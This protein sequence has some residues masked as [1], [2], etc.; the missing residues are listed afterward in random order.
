MAGFDV[1]AFNKAKFEARTEVVEVPELAE[2]NAGKPVAWTVRGLTGDEFYKVRGAA[3]KNA[4][5]QALLEA[6]SGKGLLQ[7]EAIREAF[8]LAAD[9]HEDHVKR[10]EMLIVASVDPPVDRP[11]AVKFAAAY[12]VAFARLTDKILVLTGMGQVSGKLKGSGETPASE[13][14]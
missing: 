11:M 4:Q 2:F 8:G 6:V 1:K 9:L 3:D 14:L 7:V 10:L 12:P 5:V 13:T